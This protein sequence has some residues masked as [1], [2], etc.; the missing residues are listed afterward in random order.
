MSIAA[1]AVAQVALSQGLASAAPV[2]TPPP[3][4]VAALADPKPAPEPR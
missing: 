4:T 3:R 1:F 2:K